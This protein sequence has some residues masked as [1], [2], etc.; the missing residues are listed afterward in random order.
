MRTILGLGA[1][2]CLL[3]LG[4]GAQQA[5]ATAVP[6]RP[7]ALSGLTVAWPA[8]SS[9]TLAPNSRLRIAVRPTAKAARTARAQFTFV[10]ASA[11]GRALRVIARRTLRSGTFTAAVT[12]SRAARYRLAVSSGRM[13]RTV[14]VAI[15]PLPAAAPSGPCGWSPPSDGGAPSATY[16]LTFSAVLAPD[17]VQT[18]T[19]VTA[20]AELDVS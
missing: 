16:R 8:S 20:A 5:R 14:S 12:A 7:V 3:V 19:P 18:R 13:R 4:Y 17:G 1:T 2:V 9:I 15:E 11:D 10:R 6:T